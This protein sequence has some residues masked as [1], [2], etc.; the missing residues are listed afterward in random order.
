MIESD[1][2]YQTNHCWP[3]DKFCT[4]LLGDLWAFRWE[5]RHGAASALRDLLSEPRHTRLAGMINGQSEVEVS[6]V[7]IGWENFR[8]FLSNII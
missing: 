1:D 4:L 5:I 8:V 6:F 3:L 2:L 7:L